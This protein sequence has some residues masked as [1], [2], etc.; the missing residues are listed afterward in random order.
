MA[1]RPTWEGHLR[2]SLV[3]CPV[4]LYPAISG[5]EQI[6]FH[7]INPA[8]GNRI[9]T[10]TIDPESGE[11]E[12]KEL[13][14]GYEY[15]KDQYI[16][17]T[18]EEIKSVRLESTRTIDIEHFVDAAAIDR[19]WWNDPYYLV[20]DGKAGIDAFTV[21][22]E[23][24][25][26]ASKIALARVVLGTR[27]RIVAIEPRGKGMLVTTLRSHDEVRS[28][29]ALFDAVPEAKTNAGMVDIAE[30][31]IAQQAGPFDPT[32][33]TDR[34]EEALRELIQSKQDGG[35]G[36]VTAP[37]PRDDNVIDLMEA[38]RRSLEGGSAETQRRPAA[39][40]SAKPTA[41]AAAEKPKAKPSPKPTAKTAAKP[42][43]KP[44]KRATG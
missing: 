12:R 28:E 16:L 10:Q 34:Y 20:P 37:P 32:A 39:Q 31:I 40:K 4:S 2:L 5:S 1:Q 19:I 35:G 36:G 13:V 3:A 29:K 22:R 24:M 14:R 38:L 9:R 26:H 41:K 27:E 11:V 21:I 18:D 25:A 23:A 17:L 7:L 33:F 44:R 30:R 8:T 15:E 6:R 42:A 43:P